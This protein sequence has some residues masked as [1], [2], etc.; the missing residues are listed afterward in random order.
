MVVYRKGG[1]MLCQQDSYQ[2]EAKTTVI[3]CRQTGDEWE[4]E[5]TDSLLYPMGGGQPS[6]HG[7]IGDTPIVDV[8]KKGEKSLYFTKEPVEIGEDFVRLDW[9]RRFDFMQQHTGQ[10]LLTALILKTFGWMTVGFHIGPEVSTIDLDTPSITPEQKEQILSMVNEAILSKL[11]VRSIE[12]TRTEFEKMTIRS[13]GVPDWVEGPIRLI[14]IEGVDTNNCGGT[15]VQNTSELQMFAIL[16]VER[17]KRKSRLSFVF[18]GRLL[19]LFQG[20]LQTKAKLNDIFQSGEHVE[21]AQAWAMDRKEHKR[22]R[23][24]WNVYRSKQEGHRISSL[25]TD[26]VVEFIPGMD[27]GMLKSIVNDVIV[28]NPQISLFLFSEDVFALH[29][30]DESSYQEIMQCVLALG[31][32]G[33]GRKPN[34]QGKWQSKIDFE[35]VKTRILSIF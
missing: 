17:M 26:C 22:E 1:I 3:S 16:G 35:T 23:K 13:R 4:V 33:G 19:H 5:T 20:F 21:R 10:H 11:T 24:E 32:R 6:D 12:V 7:W 18:G 29:L 30:L 15:H 27:L 31:G 8:Q 25:D 28:H 34:A 2:K 14:E 9:N